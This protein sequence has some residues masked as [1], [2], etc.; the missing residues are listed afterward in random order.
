MKERHHHKTFARTPF[1]L[2]VKGVLAVVPALVVV[3]AGCA[4][5]GPPP[6]QDDDRF[7]EVAAPWWRVG[8]YWVVSL[9]RPAAES[10]T[11]RPA[12]S[13]ATYR[14]VNFWNDSAT[15]HFWL[16]VSDRAQALDHALFDTNPFLG[17]I[18]HEI[19]APH[20]KGMHAGMYSF[21]MTDDKRWQAFILGGNWQL[22]AEETTVA[23]PRG[24]EPGF[25]VHG[26]GDRLSTITFDYVPSAQWFTSLTI[27]DA[28][29]L[30]TLRAH[31]SEY[32]H[33]ASGA[34][35]FLRGVDLYDEPA[36]DIGPGTREDP[37]TVADDFDSL[38]IYLKLTA[39]GPTNVKV[40]DPAG[41]VRF[42]RTLSPASTTTFEEKREL[43]AM[44]GTWRV[45]T[46]V[47]SGTA[48]EELLAVGIEE[49][50][51]TI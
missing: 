47:V 44:R 11:S 21:P 23:T 35:Y 19:L 30:E 31:V 38:A 4:Q 25:L 27:R 48:T 8:D 5:P 24:N 9:D 20:E 22:L 28:N 13:T 16:G 42:E 33:G 39:S 1:P 36:V 3:L 46:T 40:T 43:P 15:A 32:G 41:T 45:A 49:N 51:R 6:D 50:T 10:E 7:F 26:S 29:G 17:R 14:L 34:F 18:H 2:P 37:F 12:P